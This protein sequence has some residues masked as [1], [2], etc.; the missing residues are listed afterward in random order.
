MKFK[1]KKLITF[2]LIVTD[3]VVFG[4][5]YST[6]V[7]YTKTIII[8]VGEVVDVYLATLLHGTYPPLFTSTLVNNC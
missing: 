7:I 6:C 8:S 5:I 4:T 1:L 3:K 2:Q